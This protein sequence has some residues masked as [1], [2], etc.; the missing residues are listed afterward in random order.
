MQLP[1]KNPKINKRGDIRD[2][3]QQVFVES[4]PSAFQGMDLATGDGSSSCTEQA[5]TLA[6]IHSAYRVHMT[7]LVLRSQRLVAV[8]R[9]WPA[10]D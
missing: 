1:D 4:F 6:T 8:G 2:K 9:K 5:S 10:A 7:V 3:R